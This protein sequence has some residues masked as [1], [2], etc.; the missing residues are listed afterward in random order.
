[1]SAEKILEVEGLK[2]VFRSRNTPLFGKGGH[3]V[4]AVDNV[5][6]TLYRGETLGIVGESGCGKS[7]TARMIIGLL[8]P[9][10]GHVRFH[11]RDIQQADKQERKRLTRNLQMVFQDPFSS[12]NPRHNVKTILSEPFIIHNQKLSVREVHQAVVE[13]L[14]LIGLDE[15]A[16]K[17]YPHEFSGGQR[18][19][20]NIARAIA[21]RPEIII[22]DE[23]VSALDVSIQAQILN[24]LKRL[25]AEL[26]LTYLFVSHD[27]SVVRYI[28]DRIAVM[29]LGR[30]VE[31][32]DCDAIYRE[33]KHPYTRLLFSAIPAAT[34]FEKKTLRVS[35]VGEAA[36]LPSGSAGCAFYS[37]CDRASPRCHQPVP[38]I[39]F[40]DGRQVACHLYGA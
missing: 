18:Q 17:K 4:R 35:Q 7:T 30:I 15:S 1:M 27:L 31:M 36:A 2:K 38:D 11:G 10:G 20:L 5:S 19:R 12:L 40:D 21:L 8:Q 22:C 9:S 3:E 24:L 33:P 13:L 34:P 28:S 25:Q 26:E 16:M 32:G 37:R 14:A 23:S 39:V 6:F 29:Y